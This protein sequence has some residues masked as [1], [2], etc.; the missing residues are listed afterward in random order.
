MA[1]ATAERTINKNGTGY[2]SEVKKALDEQPQRRIRV[3]RPFGA[4]PKKV[5]ELPVII[6]GHAY[7]LQYDKFV[8]VPDEVYRILVRGGHVQPLEDDDYHELPQIAPEAA[9]ALADGKAELV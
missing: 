8:T 1:A 2:I 9:A 7:I 6:N 3:P 5:K 4:D